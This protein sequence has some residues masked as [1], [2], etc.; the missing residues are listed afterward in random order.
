MVA[1]ITSYLFDKRLHLALQLPGAAQVRHARVAALAP[2]PDAHPRAVVDYVGCW[3]GT[4]PVR[5]TLNRA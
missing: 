1:L 3:R 5:A 4:Y 2:I